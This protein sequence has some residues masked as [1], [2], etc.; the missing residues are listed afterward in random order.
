MA[1]SG[2]TNFAPSLGELGLYCFNLCG[3]RS[4]ALVQEHMESLKMAVNMVQS[5]WSAQ[6]VNLWLV[7]LQTVPLVQ[8]TS[9]YSVPSNTIVMLDG[10]IV[11]NS[12][13]AQINRLLLPISRSEYASYSNPNMQGQ[14]TVFWFDRLLAPTVTIW[15][16]PDGNQVSFD[17][18]RMVQIQDAALSNGLQVDIPYYFQEAM[19]Y[20][21]AQRL[22]IMWAPNLAAGLKALADESYQIAADQN[23]E[24][25]QQYISPMVSGYWRP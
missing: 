17:Y 11:Q 5:R 20:A 7:D 8:G 18:Y 19:A 15:P 9:T 21:I 14:P 16:V 4:T 22:A 3:I 25:A 23:I 6:G 13:G 24:T 1:T 2:T 10:Y 12:G